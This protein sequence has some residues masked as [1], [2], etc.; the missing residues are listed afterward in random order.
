MGWGLQPPSCSQEEVPLPTEACQP[1]CSEWSG[2]QGGMVADGSGK[3]C[4]PELRVEFQLQEGPAVSLS[5]TPPI[6]AL[7]RVLGIPGP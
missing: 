3:L 1:A 5:P 4:S 6:S 7:G 2:T